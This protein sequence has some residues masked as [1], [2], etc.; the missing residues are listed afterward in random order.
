MPDTVEVCLKILDTENSLL[1]QDPSNI[2]K[3]IYGEEDNLKS[4]NHPHIVK[5]FDSS[6]SHAVVCEEEG[7]DDVTFEPKAQ[8]FCIVMELIDGGNLHQLI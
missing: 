5:F 6:K 2:Q 7:K 4:L 1:G 3:Y 8:Y